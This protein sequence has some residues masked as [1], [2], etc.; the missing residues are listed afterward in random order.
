MPDDHCSIAGGAAA[1]ERLPVIGSYRPW[2]VVHCEE[3]IPNAVSAAKT[4]KGTPLYRIEDGHTARDR[5]LNAPTRSRSMRSSLRRLQ[6]EG[7]RRE[8]QYIDRRSA[9]CAPRKA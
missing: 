1:H 6:D 4:R 2:F 9:Q 5:R 8:I 7:D 3:R